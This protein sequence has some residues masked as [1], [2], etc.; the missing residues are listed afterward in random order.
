MQTYGYTEYT[1]ISGISEQ[2]AIHYPLFTT[3]GKPIS[4][5]GYIDYMTKRKIKGTFLRCRR[6]TGQLTGKLSKAPNAIVLI[7]GSLVGSSGS[8][9]SLIRREGLKKITMEVV[10]GAGGTFK[11]YLNEMTLDFRLP[12]DPMVPATKYTDVWRQTQY[13]PDQSGK[14]QV[15]PLRIEQA[16]YF[17]SLA[18]RV[19]LRP[20][21]PTFVR[22]QYYEP[23]NPVYG[24]CTFTYPTEPESLITVEEAIIRGHYESIL[25]TGTLNDADS[26]A[27]AQAAYVK[28]A[29]GLPS[30]NSNAMANLLE[31]AGLVAALLRGDVSKASKG[32]KDAWLAYRYAYTTTCLDIREYSDY[33]DRIQNLTEL[34]APDTIKCHGSSVDSNGFR[35]H[36]VM[37]VKTS[38]ALPKDM[39]STL[40]QFGLQLSKVNSWDMVPYSFVVDWFIPVSDMLEQFEAQFSSKSV[41]VTECWMSI[42]SP[43]GEH[44]LRWPYQWVQVMPGIVQKNVSKKTFWMRIADAIALFT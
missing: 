16:E 14:G 11:V 1:S 27:A 33:I 4:Q 37:K 42:E 24:T 18:R 39:K 15:G 25:A 30:V 8:R 36:C 23:R 44:Y 7:S 26:R 6:F 22:L 38:E 19:P 5:K 20:I 34:A 43:K 29:E 12:G 13:I 40:S 3:D 31:V 10:L 35:Y 32:I 17:E 2:I 21:V 9:L 28:A 41:P